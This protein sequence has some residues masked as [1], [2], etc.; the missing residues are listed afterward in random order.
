MVVLAMGTAMAMGGGELLV[1]EAAVSAILIATLDPGGTGLLPRPLPRGADRRRRGAGRERV[2][3][4]ARPGAA[5]GAG[6]QRRVRRA[7]PHAGR[8]SHGRWRT[9]T[10]GRR[11][12]RW[13]TRARSTTRSMPCAGSCSRSARRRASRRCGGARAAQIARFERSLPQVDFAVRDTRVLARN[14]VRYVRGGHPAPPRAGRGAATTS[15]AP[16]GSSPPP[17][18]TAGATPPCAASR[19]A[20]PAAPPISPR[21]G[22]TCGLTE[23][24][25]Q[26]RSV[27]VDLVRAAELAAGEPVARPERPTEEML[28]TS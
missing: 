16:S 15:P 27:A 4:P 6:A 26:V 11:A 21:T 12:A 3:V 22:A 8:R 25:V 19:S 1:S 18:T 13:R 9:A 24:G 14:V 2:P 20:P 17:T 7:R 5:G 28:T 23:I 10:A